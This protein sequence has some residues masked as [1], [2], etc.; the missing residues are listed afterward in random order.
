[1]KRIVFNSFL[2]VLISCGA[3]FGQKIKSVPKSATILETQNISPSR[4]MILWMPSSVRHPNENPGEEYTCPDRTRGSYYSGRARVTLL[5]SKTGKAINTLE[6]KGWGESDLPDDV[7]LAVDL[8][9]LI[10]S[11]Y[12]YS[13]SNADKMKE[14]KPQIMRLKDYNG[15]G[16]AREFALFDVPACQGLGTT[17]IGYDVK[18]DKVIQY[19]IKLKTEG[20]T[21]TVYWIDYLFSKKPLRKGFWKYKVDYRGRGGSLDKYEI[22]YDRKNESFVGTLKSEN[23]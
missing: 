15:D 19:A 23:S 6:I 20:R 5:D 9:Y 8:P 17:L 4:K 11:G 21:E 2:I 3:S 10:R 18:Q 12:Y 16:Q 14:R 7:D 22:R 13:V 1:M